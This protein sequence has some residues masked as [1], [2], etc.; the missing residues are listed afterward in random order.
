MSDDEELGS[1]KRAEAAFDT[2]RSNLQ[3]VDKISGFDGFLTE[4]TT[5]IAVGQNVLR[6]EIGYFGEYEG[7][8][9]SF[10]QET[11]DVLLAHGRQDAASACTMAK[12]AF[13]EAYSARR[14]TEKI[15][16]Y[17]LIS[18]MLNVVILAKLWWG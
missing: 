8:R 3:R 11:R 6:E 7:T 1:N 5:N 16:L 2:L 18:L 17:L 9:Y 13:R 10:D 4:N 12:S 14:G 15:M